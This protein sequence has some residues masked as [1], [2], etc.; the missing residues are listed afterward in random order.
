MLK[1]WL[2]HHV[3]LADLRQICLTLSI[4]PC[5]FDQHGNIIKKNI[6]SD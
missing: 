6:G 2:R 3:N 1:K 4:D 5:N